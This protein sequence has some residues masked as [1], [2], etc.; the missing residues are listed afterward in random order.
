M[1]F[2]NISSICIKL[3][4][5]DPV[6][7]HEEQLHLRHLPRPD[8]DPRTRTALQ[9]FRLA[10]PVRCRPARLLFV[11]VD[12]SP[13]SHS[14]ACGLTQKRRAPFP[15]NDS[16]LTLLV[17]QVAPVALAINNTRASIPNIIIT[18]SG[19]LRFD[20]LK[21]PFTKNDQF[22]ALPFADSFLFIPDIPLSIAAQVTPALNGV[23][24]SDKRA[25]MEDRE[26][27]LYARG[28]IDK[29]YMDWLKA[30]AERDTEIIKRA[31]ANISVGYVTKDVSAVALSA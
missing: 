15:Q 22:T 3:V 20:I 30:M 9:L 11:E 16:V 10:V 27:D 31:A 1:L 28:H 17:E 25:I 4:D 12:I 24:A 26:A 19:E 6:P 29:R 2:W 21:G 5:N 7:H 13:A 23:G 8:R 18:N 14:P